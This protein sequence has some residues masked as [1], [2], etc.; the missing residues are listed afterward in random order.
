MPLLF[1]IRFIKM[2][3]LLRIGLLIGLTLMLACN[4]EP[5]LDKQ[6]EQAI[7]QQI[8]LD[9]KSMDSLEAAIMAQMEALDSDS[10]MKDSIE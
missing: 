2:K 8:N 7:D 6:E 10:L 3:N 5:K 1:Q 9:Q 4:D